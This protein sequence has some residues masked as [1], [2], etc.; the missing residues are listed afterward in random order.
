MGMKGRPNPL[1]MFAGVGGQGLGAPGCQGIASTLV[2]TLSVST[3]CTALDGSH[4]NGSEMNTKGHIHTQA[5]TRT[6]TH[7]HTP[8]CRSFS[9]SEVRDYNSQ[10]SDRLTKTSLG[11]RV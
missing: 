7:A 5:R 10:H 2:G 3:L 8:G 11:Q 9:L 1:W 6:H 4:E